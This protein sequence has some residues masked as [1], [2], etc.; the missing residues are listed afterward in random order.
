MY[1]S[2]FSAMETAVRVGNTP[3]QLDIIN[4]YIITGLDRAKAMK[5]IEDTKSI[6]L[7][8]YE[9]LLNTM[10][11]SYLPLYWREKCYVYL[12]KMMP[13]LRSIYDMK[14]F[15]KKRNELKTL[16]SYFLQN[17]DKQLNNSLSMELKNM[18]IKE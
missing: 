1:C 16:H 9:T 12:E 5:N 15:N 14:Q 10:C 18:R 17:L 13:L 4:F 8:I 7:R 11:D 2:K 3:D 6:H